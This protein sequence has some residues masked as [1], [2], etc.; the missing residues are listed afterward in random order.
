[1]KKEEAKTRQGT[2]QRIQRQSLGLP[3][4]TLRSQ[5]EE[6]EVCADEEETQVVIGP[7]FQYVMPPW[8]P[9][10]CRLGVISA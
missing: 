6:E 7:R 4:G 5:E 3:V 8:P 9:S 2:E 10:K 1:M